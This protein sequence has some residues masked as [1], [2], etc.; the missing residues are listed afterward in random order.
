M[1]FGLK[2]TAQSFQSLMDCLLANIPYTFVYLDDILIGIPE[3]ASHMVTLRQVFGVL[4][5]NSLAINF[6]KCGFLKEQISFL[7]HRVS[8]AGVTPLGSHV[9]VFRLVSQPTAPK[10]LQ[11]FLFMDMKVLCFR[12]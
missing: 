12:P 4:D 1:S 2:N 7:G 10:G 5:S 3:V 9:D 6:G 11:C 8:T